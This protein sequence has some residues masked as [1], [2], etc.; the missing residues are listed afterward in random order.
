M[1]YRF[2]FEVGLAPVSDNTA[3][4][5][6]TRTC[7]HSDR[8]G[9][10]SAI[11]CRLLK[12]PGFCRAFEEAGAKPFLERVPGTKGQAHTTIEGGGHFLQED[13]GPQLANVLNEFIA[14]TR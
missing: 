10:T 13:C 7:I 8:L 12:D 11:K 1:G 3:V 4:F 14:A 2:V 5:S 9:R 6:E